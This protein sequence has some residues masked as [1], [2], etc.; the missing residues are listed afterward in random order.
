MAERTPGLPENWG[1][2]HEGTPDH[3]RIETELVKEIGSPEHPLYEERTQAVARCWGHCDDALFYLPDRRR[4]A[5]VH[6][7]WSRKPRSDPRWPRCDV[8]ED[9]ASALREI[10]DREE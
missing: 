8:F 9:Y 4:W 3:R 1:P 6:L 7:T 5:L 2:L 10:E